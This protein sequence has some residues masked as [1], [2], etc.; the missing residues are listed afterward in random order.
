VKLK[1]IF[2]FQS[3]TFIQYFSA[4]IH[5]KK[6]I[7]TSRSFCEWPSVFVCV[8]FFREKRVQNGFAGAESVS[9]QWCIFAVAVGIVWEVINPLMLR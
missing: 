1:Y 2:Y 3:S 9:S 8:F 7:I 5:L 6:L 4:K